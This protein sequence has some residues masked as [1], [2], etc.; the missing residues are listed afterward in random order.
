MIWISINEAVPAGWAAISDNTHSGVVGG[1]TMSRSVR[2]R[3]VSVRLFHS[4][5]WRF[6]LIR[7]ADED[8][9]GAG[10]GTGG[11]WFAALPGRAPSMWAGN[12]SV[13][14]GM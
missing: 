1:A 5:R 3:A 7:R 14:S 12:G 11:E 8:E 6:R 13:G 4:A 10:E 9:R 2:R